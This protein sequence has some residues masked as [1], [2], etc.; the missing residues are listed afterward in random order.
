MVKKTTTPIDSE[1]VMLKR[2]LCIGGFTVGLPLYYVIKNRNNI[3]RGSKIVR[4]F[5]LKELF[6]RSVL[7]FFVG[8]G[9]SIYFYG[10]GPV[11]KQEEG[12][13][14][15]DGKAQVNGKEVEATSLEFS[16]A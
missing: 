9:A 7:G 8:V 4:E 12:T 16:V 2:K 5:Y 10:V 14:G 11:N 1:E 13:L 3:Y 15:K 6:A